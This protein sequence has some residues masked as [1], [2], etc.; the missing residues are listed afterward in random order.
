[1][2]RSVWCVLSIVLSITSFAQTAPPEK[3]TAEVLYVRCGRLV[4]DTDKPALTN[5]AV[6]IT[7]GK[8]TAVGEN[9]AAPAGAKTVDFSRYTVLPGLLDAH[10]H[11]Y[12]GTRNENPSTA[13]ASLRAMKA[14]Q[15]ALS[16]GVVAMRVLGSFDF[17]DVALGQASDEG[18]ILAPHIVAAAHAISIPG[19]HGDFLPMP[20]QLQIT[21]Y[22]TPMNGFINSPDD[23][24][25]AVHLQIKYGARV[26][27]VLASGGVL[28]PLDSP[29]AEQ[30]SSEELKVIVQQAHM[31]NVKVAAHAENIRSIM[32]SLEAGVDSIEHGSDLN[33][34][35]VDFMKA[36]HVVLTPTLFVPDHVLKTGAQSHLP[37]YVMQ[38]AGALA[39]I[40]FAS[41]DLARKAGVTMAAGSDQ[42]YGA[43]QG[44]V[45][46][47]LMALVAHG[48]TAQ[49]ALT[50]ATKTNADLMS[51]PDLGTVAQGKEGD[52]LAVDGDPLTNIQALKNVQGVIF[53][54][55][56]VP[57][58][59]AKR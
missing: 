1:M 34:Q 8:I 22:Y 40:T 51:L 38:K 31:A 36:H 39:K 26:I 6:V 41:F 10:T 7:D 12:T 45:T 49:Q 53:K 25:K 32:E 4:T 48:M 13:L 35:A 59:F 52:L 54:G 16:Q 11:L 44:T 47:E 2:N 5:A 17:V 24:E 29:T 27:K 9:L 15:Y 18:T 37:E 28:S 57:A 33:Q 20:P 14:V 42:S 23:A 56:V 19:G 30:V 21:D 46:D 58:N 43:G 55:M 50:A 3:K